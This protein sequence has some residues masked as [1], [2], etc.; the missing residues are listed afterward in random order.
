MGSSITNWEG[1]SG[2]IFTGAG[3]AMPGIWVWVAIAACVIPLIISAMRD[4]SSR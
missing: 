4:G 3:S 2:A 1:V